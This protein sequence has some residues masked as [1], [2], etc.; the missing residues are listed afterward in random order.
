MEKLK[1]ADLTDL[2]AHTD[3]NP[4]LDEKAGTTA[5]LCEWAIGLKASD[6]PPAVLSRVKHLILDGLA[7]G[8][9]GGHVPW[10]EQAA[11]AIY[12]YEPPG[13][14]SVIGY[15]DEPLG[16]L[17]AAILNG[18]FI[19]ATELDDYHSMAP[20]HSASVVVPAIL[21]AAQFLST[22]NGGRSKDK[23]QKVSGLDFLLAAIVG[24]ETGPRVGLAT[25]GG[26]LLV[27]GWHSGAIFGCPAAA[28]A[29]SRL[30][31]LSADD[32]ESAI[33]IACTQAGGLMSATYE[34]MIKRVQHAFAARN[35]LFGALLARNGYVGIK[36]VF[37]RRYGGFLSMFSKG[38]NRSPP[39]D[40]R[41]VVEEIGSTWQIF[42]IRV[43]L[44]A[45]VGGCHG[46]IEAIAKLQAD[47]PERFAAEALGKIVSIK[48]GLSGPIFAHDGW[49]PH[50]R[51]LATTGA[52]MN[53]AYIGA[54]QLVD[55]QVL[56]AQFADSSLNRDDVWE[57]VYKTSC[58]H[59][60]RFDQPHYGCGAR[61]TVVFDDGVTLEGIVDQP[62]GFDP[63]IQDGEIAEK[64]RKLAAS[65]IADQERIDR[66][67]KLV[68]G[69]E[70]LEDM[71]EIFELL[72]RPTAK[73]L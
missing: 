51:P 69:L 47:H 67:E 3:D 32:T 43:K 53:A 4:A 29:S 72:A 18:A 58:F 46:Q 70:E 8:L 16:P 55:R 6:V 23:P 41:R 37:E 52:Q 20:L 27:R 68:L 15:G 38:T 19:Q 21:S 42:N 26:E 45:C 28:V 25:G 40:V 56:L 71:S 59:D 5:A 11:E 50:E 2:H 34:G 35:G 48:V 17:A 10:S 31:G 1:Y 60:T 49:A 62:R 54:V 66:L 65:A 39:Y 63:P 73:V 57:L 12:G 64:Y 24:F 7:C 30:L 44:H 9:V 14:C 36:K 22:G 13:Y 61:V 33:G